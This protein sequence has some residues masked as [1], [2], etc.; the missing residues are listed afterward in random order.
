MLHG[1]MDS[2]LLVAAWGLAAI[3][4]NMGIGRWCR[5]HAPADAG[6]TAPE[7]TGVHG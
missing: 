7:S 3:A 5:A 2:S 6:D 1:G 4:L